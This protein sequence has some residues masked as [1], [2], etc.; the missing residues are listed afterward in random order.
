MEDTLLWLKYK[1]NSLNNII[2]LP[3]IRCMVENGIDNHLIL[4][5]EFGIG[6]SA[7]ADLL[8]KDK[9]TLRN[10]TSKDTSIEILRKDIDKHVNTMSDIF[11]PTDIF[12]YVYLAEFEKASSA[13]QDALKAYIDDNSHLVRFIFVTNHLHKI[14]NGIKTRCSLLGFD[15]IGDKEKKWWKTKCKERLIAIAGKENIN[16]N[17]TNIKKIVAHNYPSLRNMI[18]VLSEVAKTGIIDYDINIFKN[19]LK[20]ELYNT[21]VNKNIPEI[22]KFIMNNYGPENIQ[23]LF[24]LCGRP[25][26]ELMITKRKDLLNSTIFGEIYSMVAE[27]SMW[28]NTIKGGDPIVVATSLLCKIKELLRNEKS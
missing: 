7:L 11:D 1:P 8:T 17:E 25:L 24:N 26:L 4:H 16:I 9:P 2:L 15:P 3:R 13:F 21:I 23:E 14:D 10:N 28:L 12:K 22:Q 19:E 27:H 6:K 20:N 5:G 18:I